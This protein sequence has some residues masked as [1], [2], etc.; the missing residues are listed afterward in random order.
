MKIAITAYGNT[1]DDKLDSRF[2]RAKG[3]LVYD[4]ENGSVDF[5]DNK[6][7]YNA[8]QGAGIQAAQNVAALDVQAVITG[9]CG[10]K[11]F[12]VLSAAKIMVYNSQAQTVKE[13]LQLYKDDKLTPA[14]NADVE[15]HWI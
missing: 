2:G 13:A 5:K 15:G 12:S 10:P 9:H 3:F 14:G 8:P 7:N 11:A 1:L 4:T 6:Q